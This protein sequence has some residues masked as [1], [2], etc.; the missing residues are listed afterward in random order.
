MSLS[1]ECAAALLS[2]RYLS[3]K[4]KVR[5]EAVSETS[6]MFETNGASLRAGSS[7]CRSAR[8]VD[9]SAKSSGEAAKRESEPVLISAIF[10]IVG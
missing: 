7:L 4:N 2:F 8:G 10:K 3:L 6:G 9:A 5:G 1:T